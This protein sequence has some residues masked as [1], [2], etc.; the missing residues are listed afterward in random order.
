MPLE[1]LSRVLDDL[2]AGKGQTILLAGEAGIGKTR[3]ARETLQRAR[4]R[5]FF[6]LQGR[7]FEQ[8]RALPYAPLMDLLRAFLCE[9]D[10]RE[11]LAPFASE[12]APLLSALESAP[13]ASRT[14]S[15]FPVSSLPDAVQAKRKGFL[16]LLQ[17][18]SAQ[19][20][21][22]VV[23]EDLHWADDVTLEFL[24]FLAR[25][26]SSHAILVLLTYRADELYPALSHFLAVLER[27]RVATEIEV[28][29]LTRVETEQM[30][31]A[32]F[33]QPQPVRADF[34]EALYAR[35]EGNP[36]FIEET[37]RTLVNAGDIFLT[38]GGWERKALPQLHIPRTVQDAV[39][40]RTAN[41][42]ETT[43]EILQLAAV[44]GRRFDF[45]LLRAVTGHSEAEV[46]RALKELRAAQLVIEE[47]AD[48]FAFRHALT[49]EAVYAQLLARE[50]RA[51][52]RK[53]LET[54]ERVYENALE[55]R[56]ADLAY[57]AFEAGEWGRAAEYAQRAGAQARG[58]FAPRAAIEQYTR[59]VEAF[60]RLTPQPPLP[61]KS[62][63]IFLGEGEVLRARAG[64]YELVGEFDA[65]RADYEAALVWAE[66]AKDEAAQ[67]ELQLALGFLWAGRDHEKT[68]AHLERA[69]ELAR[70]L[71][72]AKRVAHTLNRIGNW[73][74]NADQPTEGLRYHQ[75]AFAL[76]QELNDPMG[77][78]ETHDLSG[79]ANYL[80]GDL[81]Q[82][83][84]HFRQAAALLRERG[85]RQALSSV[86]SMSAFGGITYFTDSAF[87]MPMNLAEGRRLYQEAKE[88][89]R[90]I[91]WRFGEADAFISLGMSLGPYGEYAAAFEYVEQGLSIAREIE[92][93]MEI[94]FGEMTLGGL[95]LDVLD[96]ARARLHLER[97]GELAR[98]LNARYLI[99]LVNGFLAQ[100]YLAQDEMERAQ[101]LLDEMLAHIPAILTQPQRHAY[102]A[103][104]ELLLARGEYENAL[105]VVEQIIVSLPRS[106]ETIPIVP[107]V[108]RSRGE[109]LV[110]LKR[111]RE[112]Q[113]TLD[114]ARAAAETL[115]ARPQLWRI[116]V[117]LG[118]LYAAQNFRERAAEQFERARALI[119]TLA[120][121][122]ADSAL[123]ENFVRRA[124]ALIPQSPSLTTK[125]KAKLA[126]GGLTARERELARLIAQGK[127]NREIG[128]ELVVSERTVGA[129]VQNIL[130]KLGFRTRAQ[131]AV[132]AIQRMK[133][134]G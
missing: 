129:H 63:A 52:H 74:A 34:L 90:S 114:A 1:F 93:R 126:A 86:L 98:A 112:A 37:L 64:Q 53:I 101:T 73:H 13:Y 40:A 12:L 91:E 106:S 61:K 71:E 8:D 21:R 32:L 72:D 120:A 82:G 69:L 41:M 116:D 80:L 17:F 30:V 24:L 46:L 44:A 103:R 51:A 104:A 105:R 111:F 121:P 22:V 11:S 48:Q 87:W 58:L 85:E 18:F 132:W 100:A 36:F 128:Q 95:Y 56:A 133:D 113:E 6:I 110:S 62:R 59:A 55:A 107:R 10:A 60:A 96:V 83:T 25:Q 57:H 66:K 38:R 2:R 67:W 130:G 125:Q 3:L 119:E 123:R 39:V 92:H 115:G 94:T 35:T 31:R 27:E 88:L 45:E 28:A 84:I 65:A 33:P 76:F 5:D 89:A 75:E 43:R 124:N 50:R 118:K 127:S 16:A 77:L 99:S 19:T 117:A 109:A 81:G 134:E 23:I 70:A 42:S 4:E 49:R 102:T 68:R 15:T 20:P 9:P 122:L 79:T 14:P 47:S 108:W 97:A 78:A 7:C 54:L 131:I 26:I 29:P